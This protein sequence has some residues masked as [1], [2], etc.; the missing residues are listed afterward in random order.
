MHPSPAAATFE[1]R[2][3][4]ATAALDLGQLL[5]LDAMLAA[6]D[7]PVEG[8]AALSVFLSFAR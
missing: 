4:N 3:A 5:Q 1:Q 8:V 6:I 7:D 2:L